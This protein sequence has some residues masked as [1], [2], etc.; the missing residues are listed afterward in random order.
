LFWNRRREMQV[1]HLA[2]FPAKAEPPLESMLGH[3]H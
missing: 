3:K 1:R 2:R